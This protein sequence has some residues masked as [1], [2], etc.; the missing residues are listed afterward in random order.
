M[1]LRGQRLSLPIDLAIP[2]NTNMIGIHRN[3]QC[4]AQLHSIA[5]SKRINIPVFSRIGAARQNCI[6]IKVQR[7]IT[8]ELNRPCEISARGKPQRPPAPRASFIDRFLQDCGVASRAIPDNPELC[9]V[10][11][12]GT[13]RFCRSHGWR[14]LGRRGLGS[15]K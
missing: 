5:G 6:R 13:W 7:D 4:V 8:F 10:D 1:L 15:E 12:R 3:N 2:L 9:D 14:G 11:D